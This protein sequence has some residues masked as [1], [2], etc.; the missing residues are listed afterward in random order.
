MGLCTGVARVLPGAGNRLAASGCGSYHAGPE[1]S[2]RH[3]RANPG[4]SAM[5]QSIRKFSMSPIGKAVFILVLLTFGAGFWYV[6]NPLAPGGGD[7]AVRVGDVEIPAQAISEDYQRQMQRLRQLSGQSFDAE[8]ARAMGLPQAVIGQIVNRTL[9]DLGASD[10]G[11]AVSDATIGK[12][13][14]NDPDF[15]NSEGDFDREVYS[16]ALRNA[17]FS[18]RQYEERL[19]RDLARTEYIGTLQAGVVAPEALVDQAY[20]FR[21][22]ARV[23]EVVPI[24]AAAMTAV[25]EPDAAALQAYYDSHPDAFTTPEIRQVTAVVLTAADL[26]AEMAASEEELQAAYDEHQDEYAEPERRSLQQ[27]LFPDQASAERA[28]E[29]LKQG[30]DF[31]AVAKEVAGLESSDLDIGAMSREELIPEL[32]DAVFATAHGE[33]TAPIRSP[34]GWHLIRVTEVQPARTRTLAEAR[35]ELSE[36]IARE[37]AVDAL[38]DLSTR[39]EDALGGG[40][41]LEDAARS[42][43]LKLIRVPALDAAGR[44]AEGA[45]VAD[46][47]PELPATAFATDVGSDSLLTQTGSDGYFIVRVDTATPPQRKPLD[48]VRDE[49]RDAVMAERRAEAAR[50]AAEALAAEVRGGRPIG[51]A[52]RDKGYEAVTGAPVKR[53]GEGGEPGWPRSLVSALFETE[54][55]GVVVVDAGGAVHVARVREVVEAEPRAD[56][57]AVATLRDE[58]T[59]ALQTD[60]VDQLA[61][62]LQRRHP[63]EANTRVLSDLF[64]P[65]QQQ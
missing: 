43:N 17:G 29:R 33:V 15:R 37:K 5:M 8:Q 18:E 6:G 52:A 26:A 2:H 55:G 48:A 1:W 11:L 12:V 30:A 62:A 35:D 22:E 41:S 53:S 57:E 34:L 40:A 51:E 61:G 20:R 56:R 45:A 49:V 9:L 44:D 24:A 36:M 42:L 46:I 50:Q 27:I 25:P 63:V 38:Y 39:L 65:Q 14:R 3:V 31:A 28:A 23:A 32:A 59:E 47:P 60:I 4:L 64:Q 19:R 13:I 10:L 21:N 16:L 54:P 58:L 7:W